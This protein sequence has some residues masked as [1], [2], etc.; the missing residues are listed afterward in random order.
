MKGLFA[1]KLE[2]DLNHLEF[3]KVLSLVSLDKK[4]KAIKFLKKEDAYR[5]V[6][7]EV[8]IRDIISNEL[9]I[10]NEDIFFKRNDYGKPF[11]KNNPNFH[12]N[13]SHSGSW[14]VCAISNKQIGIDIE[15]IENID[16]NIAKEFFSKEEYRNLI[17][18]DK[19][20]RLGYFY[21]LWTSKE[22]YIKAVGKGLS[23]PLNSFTVKD[24]NKIWLNDKFKFSEF[25]L[26]TYNIGDYYKLTVCNAN[27]LFPKRIIKKDWRD[28]LIY[29]S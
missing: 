28:L 1:V 7:G 14:I 22:S 3:S 25:V 5:T 27:N 4:N 15:K 19:K 9:K 18:K 10:K 11:L 21:K 23:I 26:K 29:F 16:L 17:L 6:I 2:N 24:N 20:D 8:L 12:F 13:I